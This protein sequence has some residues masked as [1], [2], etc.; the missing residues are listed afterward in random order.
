MSNNGNGQATTTAPRFRLNGVGKATKQSIIIPVIEQE[1]AGGTPLAAID[2]KKILLIAHK[3][4]NDIP[5]AQRPASVISDV[6][7]GFAFGQCRKKQR[8]GKFMASGP[9]VRPTATDAPTKHESYTP[10]E[11]LAAKRYLA[12]FGGSLARAE[13]AL[14][15]VA[16]LT[17]SQE[18]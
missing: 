1:V 2:R 16:S 18:N 4:V 12:E 11:L 7:I 6:D 15:L 8:K 5:A 13:T 17:L 9:V 14:D 3:R 10:H